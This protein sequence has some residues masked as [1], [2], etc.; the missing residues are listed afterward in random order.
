[1]QA[2]NKK[3]ALRLFKKSLKVLEKLQKGFFRLYVLLSAKDVLLVF[4]A[5]LPLLPLLFYRGRKEK[6]INYVLHYLVN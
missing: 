4:F 6:I 2:Y 3:I 1:M 5:A